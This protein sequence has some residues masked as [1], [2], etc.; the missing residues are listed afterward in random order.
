MGNV[1]HIE[2]HLQKQIHKKDQI[3]R[4]CKNGKPLRSARPYINNKAAISKLINKLWLYTD[5]ELQKGLQ[6][7]GPLDKFGHS[8]TIKEHLFL[9][10]SV[11]TA[12]YGPLKFPWSTYQH[13]AVEGLEV[14]HFVEVDRWRVLADVRFPGPSG[15]SVPLF[16][17]KSMLES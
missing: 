4:P 7:T 2:H 5:R 6:R 9:I 11:S 13:Q 1:C 14:L 17:D 3:K 10:L 8:A 12:S 15:W 16:V